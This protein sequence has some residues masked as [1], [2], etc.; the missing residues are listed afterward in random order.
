[1]RDAAVCERCDFRSVCPDSAAP[2]VPTRE[3]PLIAGESVTQLG[4]AGRISAAVSY[5]LF[6]APK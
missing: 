3:L 6:G 5:L 4:P 2:G 1:M